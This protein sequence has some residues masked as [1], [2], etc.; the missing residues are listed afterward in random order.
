[1]AEENSFKENLNWKKLSID[2]VNTII[3]TAIGIILGLLVDNWR[4]KVN[5]QENYQ[6]VIVAT[7]NNLENY[8]QQMTDIKDYMQFSKEYVDYYTSDDYEITDST[9]NELA[10]IF[11]F[12]DFKQ[13][14]RWIEE[15]FISNG[16]FI[17][18]TD[19]R[20][21]IGNVYSLVD[22]CRSNVTELKASADKAYEKYLEYYSI[23]NDTKAFE[24]FMD[25]KTIQNYTQNLYMMHSNVNY[26]LANMKDLIDEII[27]M[28]NA[29]EEA[30][31][32]MRISSKKINDLLNKERADNSE[33]E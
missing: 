9:M 31:K 32:E 12:S 7:I 21:K 33:Q 6:K 26:Y 15:N 25:D 14:D 8:Q 4:E 17:E 1:M 24:K 18:N 22:L 2:A 3:A 5:N 28:S 27:K 23:E 20:L 11:F 10:N 19:L 13:Q 29:D 16:G 30:L